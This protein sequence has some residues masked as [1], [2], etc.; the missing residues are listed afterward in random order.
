VFLSQLAQSHDVAVPLLSSVKTSN[1]YH[2]GWAQRRLQTLLDGVR[3]KQVAVWGLT[4]KPGTDTLRRSSAIELCEWLDAH[5]AAARAH[6][7]A[8]SSLPGALAGR[9][10]LAASP[11]E[12]VEGAAAL[13]VATPWPA[14]RDVPADEVRTRMSGTLVL[15]PNRFLADTLGRHAALRYVS[16]GKGGR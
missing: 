3:G 4:Y 12:A 7:P 13:V 5:G 15:D 11:L 14:Y 9:V 6:D 2:R 16:V 1:D 10:R 8:V